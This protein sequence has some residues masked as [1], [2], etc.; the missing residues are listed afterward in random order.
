M[1]WLVWAPQ[2]SPV[3]GNLLAFGNGQG[4]LEKEFILS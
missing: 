3:G 2:H 4:V 1:L